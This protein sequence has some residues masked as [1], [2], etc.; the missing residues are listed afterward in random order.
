MFFMLWKRGRGEAVIMW[1]NNANCVEEKMKEKQ[2]SG[3]S[4]RRLLLRFRKEISDGP[5][6]IIKDL[7]LVFVPGSWYGAPET[8][9]IS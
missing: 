2:D 1:K 6:G 8:L 7:Y 5:H 4:I 3:R 9:S